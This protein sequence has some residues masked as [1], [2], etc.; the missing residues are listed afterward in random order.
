M[1]ICFAGAGR[2][3]RLLLSLALG[4][5]AF[6]APTFHS[7]GT[8]TS[9][10]H[11]VRLNRQGIIQIVD[12]RGNVFDLFVPIENR[13]ATSAPAGWFTFSQ[14]KDAR[15]TLDQATRTHRFDALL[16]PA[17]VQPV[18]VSYGYQLTT[19]GRVRVRLKV[20]A[21]PGVHLG[22]TF[23]SRLH[24]TRHAAVGSTVS[25][26][27]DEFAIASDPPGGA[28][29]LR[30][31]GAPVPLVFHPN[32]ASRRLAFHPVK[33]GSVSFTDRN[34]V[35]YRP[36]FLEAV[37]EMRGGELVYEI[38][39]PRE[40]ERAV[41]A[42]TYGGVDFWAADRLAMPQYHQSRNLVQNPGFEAG[43]AY[44]RLN[45]FGSAK[46]APRHARY[47]DIVETAP[48]SGRRALALRGEP[49]LDPAQ[50][51][52][53]AIP[54][55][56]GA[57]YTLSFHARGT[58]PDQRL[59]VSAQGFFVPSTFPVST[60][61][62]LTERWE[63]HTFT[64]DAPH[65]MLSV[66]FG[67]HGAREEGWIF[68]D[69]VQLEKAGSATDFT[70]K[71]LVAWLEA[72]AR[73]NLWQ[74][75][76][77]PRAVLRVSGPPGAQ[78]AVRVTTTDFFGR[79]EQREPV[80]LRLD[81]EGLGRAPLF[82][83]ASLPPGMHVAT[84]ELRSGSY[85]GKDYARL[86]VMPAL[87]N[88]HRHKDIFSAHLNGERY[89]EWEREAEFFKRVGIGS[90]ILFDPAPPE[91]HAA[92]RR[93]GI[94]HFSSIFDAGHGFKSMN[95]QSQKDGFDLSQDQLRQ[96]EEESFKKASANS[97]VTHWKLNNEPILGPYINH[98]A[99]M[100]KMIAALEA[101]RRGIL[102]ANPAAKIIGSDPANMYANSGQAFM[103]TMLQVLAEDRRQ[104]FDIAA[105]H[106]YRARPE[107]PDR[108]AETR[109]FLALLER[110][111]FKGDVWFTEGIYHN[112][113]VVPAWDLNTHVGC[114]TDGY[115]AG[116]LSYAMG[117]GERMAAA[118]T[119][120]SWLV[121]LKYAER[122]KLDVDWGFRINAFS[123]VDHTPMAPAFAANTL[124]GLLGDATFKSD[125]ALGYQVRCYV[126]ED[127]QNRPVAALWSH[128]IEVDKG[129]AAAP[130]L[131]VSAL[132][133]AQ[134]GVEL[135]DF[136]G[137][138]HS[139]GATIEA[140]PFPVFLRGPAGATAAFTAALAECRLVDDRGSLHA[141]LAPASATELEIVVENS[142]NRAFS[143]V[144]V[145][146]EDGREVARSSVNIPARGEWKHRHPRRL[147][148]GTL[149][150]SRLT[151]SLHPKNGAEERDFELERSW[152]AW[153]KRRAPITLSG[154]PEEWR[155]AF[156]LDLS[157]R[158]DFGPHGLDPAQ[159]R[160][161][162]DAPVAWSGPDDFSARF[163]ATWDEHHLY[164]ALAVRDDVHHPAESS[165]HVWNA[166]SVQ[167]YFDGWADS[168]R[169][170]T[171]GYGPD[172]QSF[173]LWPRLDAPRLFRD[174][175]PE[176]QLAFLDL[177]PVE[178]ARLSVIRLQDRVTFYE[179]ALPVADLNPVRLVAGA[180]FG[181]AALVNDHDRDHRKRALTLT[182]PGT[183]PYR[184][185][186]LY[187]VVLLTP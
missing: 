104:L 95:W 28:R 48:H 134:P 60:Q 138:S 167:L 59:S 149:T 49:G 36:P 8:I 76:E 44:W 160:R 83:A 118:Y 115:R 5:L 114:S 57:R 21:P 71:P 92:L 180:H 120:R 35:S 85:S 137:V 56:R 106:P 102:R 125:V 4:T 172:D 12:D 81:A 186:D 161:F 84:L 88:R 184:R 122:V 96:V 145:V 141:W 69:S 111:G 165:T 147:A 171:R 187:P 121:A 63:R 24:V 55:D 23:A 156:Q 40:V 158:L 47:Y 143:G 77:D 78:V 123:D 2:A 140:S 173:Q 185:P 25:A 136:M 94:F 124:G 41:S 62:R 31:P 179:V 178:D 152:M 9:G 103:D 54:V 130:R 29:I 131:D 163:Y 112:N 38:E 64:F 32:D 19:E 169:S 107:E 66:G 127:G 6:G 70:T 14:L 37:F 170:R 100:R 34:T 164:L 30:P 1:P 176:R 155:D 162:R 87:E 22:A 27:P 129:T 50:V 183:E 79:D 75:G 80:D 52:S 53:F 116:P 159:M 20:D 10:G 86:V 105:I 42:E 175:A 3:C 144:A 157:N 142:A 154:R 39:L 97:D 68:V 43:F 119:A 51:A 65:P 182:P 128:D 89:V 117:W 101:A 98:P 166:D 148:P 99:N 73:G 7:D 18:P 93:H 139:P 58:R 72:G 108:D 135:I 110:R 132:L 17:G 174:V 133:A 26:G 82:W 126:F 13:L 177:G 168:V 46:Q 16:D 151:V 67:H 74:P 150:T 91:F 109:Q 15:A 153:P 45:T 90:T 61:I 113:Y 11:Q 181:F 146:S 33:V